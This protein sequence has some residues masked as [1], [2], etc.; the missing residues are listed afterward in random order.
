MLYIKAHYPRH[1]YETTFLSLWEYSFNPKYHINI[2]KPPE[3][4]HLLSNTTLGN[5]YSPAEIDQILAGA[6][7]KEYKDLLTDQ[8]KKVVEQY[9][10]FGA[11]WFWLSKDKGEEEPVFGS[12]RF[13]YIYDFLGVPWRDVE[14]VDKDEVRGAG[15]GKQERAIAKL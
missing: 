2:S 1:T 4:R 9:G 14:I 10:A 13:V 5:F 7:S 15:S 6:Q 11:P 12:D 3:L 8:T